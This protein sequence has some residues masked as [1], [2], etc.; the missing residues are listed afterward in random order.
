VPFKSFWRKVAD[1]FGTAGS[2]VGDTE[3]T[4][5]FWEAYKRFFKRL[6]RRG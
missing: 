4:D 6:F 2:S 5:G 3:K 1:M